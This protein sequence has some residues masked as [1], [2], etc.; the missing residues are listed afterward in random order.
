MNEYLLEKAKNILS[1]LS[2]E[3]IKK[4]LQDFGIDVI[5]DK[6]LTKVIQPT[7]QEKFDEAA[8]YGVKFEYGED[9][10]SVS[11]Y[12]YKGVFYVCDVRVINE[13]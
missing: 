8:Q 9:G 12:W 2:K 4:K 5:E 7:P 11:G 10:G 3:E 1:N 6:N 13:E